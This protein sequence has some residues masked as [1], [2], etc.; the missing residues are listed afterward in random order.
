[1]MRDSSLSRLVSIFYV[2][3]LVLQPLW[4]GALHSPPGRY[5]WLLAL[6]AT[7]PLLPPLRGILAGRL[8]SMTW[9]GYLLVAYF[10]IGIMEAWSN[11]ARRLPA[12]F[13]IVLAL[14]YVMCLVLLARRLRRRA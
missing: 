7:L 2:A 12:L 11:P 9:G 4:H 10:V 5:A 14:S 13:Q 1:M 3:V 8:R 6:V